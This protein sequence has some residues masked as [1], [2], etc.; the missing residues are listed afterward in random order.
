MNHCGWWASTTGGVT[1][2][3]HR[4]AVSFAG[5]VVEKVDELGDEHGLAFAG[6][7]EHRDGLDEVVRLLRDR[8]FRAVADEY[9]SPPSEPKSNKAKKSLFPN[10]ARRHFL[11]LQQC[12]DAANT[13]PRTGGGT[14]TTTNEARGLVDR[15]LLKGVLVRGLVLKCERCRYTDFYPLARLGRGF[16]CGR[17]LGGQPLVAPSWFG[18]GPDEPNSYYSLDELAFQAMKRNVEG[19][20]LALAALGADASAARHSW[21][22]TLKAPDETKQATLELDFACLVHGK[23]Y[24]GEAKTNGKLCDRS[25]K[26]DPDDEARKTLRGA[27]LLQADFVVFSTTTPT[28]SRAA[29]NAVRALNR[30]RDK[31]SVL[32]LADTT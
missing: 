12:V 18:H 17:C 4:G 29:E 6:R 27:R 25:S 1:G 20:A 23:L 22:I 21:S 30:T 2:D 15:L 26:K 5:A 28:W 3:A 9:L 14:R 11:T 13:S 19:P 31:P 16:T 24:A 32:T 7:A 10:G 8:V